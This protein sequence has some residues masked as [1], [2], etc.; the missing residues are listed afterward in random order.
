MTREEM[1]SKLSIDRDEPPE[2]ELQGKRPGAGS[3]PLAAT[4]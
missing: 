2:A 1:L 4:T 3:V